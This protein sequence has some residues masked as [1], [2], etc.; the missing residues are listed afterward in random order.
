SWKDAQVDKDQFVS[1]DDIASAIVNIYKMSTGA[2][3]DE[4]IIKPAGG[5]V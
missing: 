4:I 5:Q 1:P 3:V 2:N